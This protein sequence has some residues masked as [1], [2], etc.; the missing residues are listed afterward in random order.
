MKAETAGLVLFGLAEPV[1][2]MSGFLPSPATGEA[3]AA[4]SGG[5]REARLARNMTQG[6]ILSIG[7]DV[8]IAL[9]TYPELGNAVWWLPVAGTAIILFFCWEF[10]SAQAQGR[11]LGNAHQGLG[12]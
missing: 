4:T 9:M 5:H 6:A 10:R 7:I 2:V 11:E 12:Y 8:A 1:Q 3:S